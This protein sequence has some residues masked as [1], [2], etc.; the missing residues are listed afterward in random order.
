VNEKSEVANERLYSEER[1]QGRT[2]EIMKAVAGCR[3]R[4][5][6]R[7]AKN[8]SKVP[9]L[10]PWEKLVKRVKEGH[11]TL[12]KNNPLRGIVNICTESR[13]TPVHKRNTT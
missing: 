11:F 4:K 8:Q 12:I 1:K 2:L 7:K 10:A 6:K 5:A 3:N 13:H 9:S